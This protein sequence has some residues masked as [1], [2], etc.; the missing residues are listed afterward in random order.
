MIPVH[1]KKW[2]IFFLVATS[3]FMSTLDSS[4]VNVA[5]PYMLQDLQTELQ[6]IQWV[7]LIYL[8]TV[9]SLL[10][11]FGRL[12]DIKGR[13][14]VYVLGFTIFVAGSLLCGMAVTPQFL[15]M[16][17]A[18]QGCGAAMLMAC[19]PALI[20]DVFPVQERGKALGMIGAVV[21]AGLTTGPVVGG[22][23]LEYLSWRYIF[24]INIPIGIA[25]AI[26]GYFVLKGIPTAKGSYEPM[27]KTGSFL[28][29][30]ILSSLIIFLTQLSRWGI[31]SIPSLSF[32]G[33][34][35]LASIGFVLNEARSD[36]PLFD[37]ALLKIK[38]FV[39]PVIGSAV[40]FAA[41]FV[42]VFMLPFYLTY[43]C[44]FSASK[45]GSIMIVLFLF[46][47]FVS[48]VS[49]IL[50]DT[51]GSRRLCMM[52]MS[53]L[54]LSLVSLMYIH[55]S[56][57]VV[58]IL[59]RIAL[60]GIGTAL[61]VS[62]NNTAIMSCVPLPRRGIASG[63]VATARNLGMVIGVATAGLIFS[64][65]FSSLT[66]GASLEN[67]LAEME[68]FFM[69]SFKQTMAMGAIISTFGIFITF[70]RGKE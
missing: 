52:G 31:I 37:L 70:A 67:Y 64:T 9:S 46:L 56:M 27:D 14:P 35:I 1:E 36:Y 10:L 49:G 60:A 68:P 2:K 66:S 22:I 65:S 55:P 63:S 59:W 47:L 42:I 58:S 7:V 54:T 45:T 25:A 53:V 17:R 26:G 48:P 34:C 33:L 29:I 23:I 15:I 32:A 40:L 57:G 11:T 43:P 44:G 50:Y 30:I 6:T 61:Y 69:I 62:P 28:L 12:S 51:F 41:L 38:L 8:V 24:Y 39:F 5:L 21:A 18:L 16:S 4:I 19:S 3:I 20:V 13:Q